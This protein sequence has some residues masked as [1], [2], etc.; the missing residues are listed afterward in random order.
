MWED[1]KIDFKERGYDDMDWIKVAKN[2]D[3]WHAIVKAK[4]EISGL[5]R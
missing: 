2:Y 5:K 1:I 4:N 3:Q